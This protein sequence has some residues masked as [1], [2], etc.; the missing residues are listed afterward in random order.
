[1]SSL[2]GFARD[3]QPN[4]N[5]RKDKQESQNF[6]HNHLTSMREQEPHTQL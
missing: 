6:N 5:K 2:R 1:M 4:A 3:E